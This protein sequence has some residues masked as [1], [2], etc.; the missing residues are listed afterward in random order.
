MKNKK[1]A[2]GDRPVLP[3]LRCGLMFLFVFDAVFKMGFFNKTVHV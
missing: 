2:V 1:D 3:E